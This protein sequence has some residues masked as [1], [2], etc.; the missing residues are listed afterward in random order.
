MPETAV[1]GYPH[2]IKGEGEHPPKELLIVLHPLWGGGGKGFLWVKLL[3]PS[4]SHGDIGSGDLIA[5][6]L[7]EGQIS[8]MS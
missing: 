3:L 2:D 6:M 8:E 7:C 4:V 5:H 1:I